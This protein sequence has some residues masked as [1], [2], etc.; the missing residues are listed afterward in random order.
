MVVFGLETTFRS[1]QRAR[2]HPRG[3]WNIPLCLAAVP[4][5]TLLTWTPSNFSQSKGPCLAS[6]IWWTATYAELGIVIATSLIFTYSLCALV[7]TLQL[8]RRLQT[9]RDERIAAARVVYYLVPSIVLLVW[10]PT[11][12][13]DGYM[14]KLDR[15]S[16]Y[17]TTSQS[18]PTGQP[19]VHL[20]LQRS[21]STFSA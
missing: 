10:Y 6:L 2:F 17:L 8:L 1:L 21:L 9:D 14:L 19:F 5:L 12:N 18:R 13:I 16:S 3:K 7:I 11:T 20:R 15:R 4:I